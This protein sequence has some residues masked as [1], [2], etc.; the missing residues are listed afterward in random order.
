MDEYRVLQDALNIMKYAQSLK[1]MNQELYDH[2]CGSILYIIRYAD[3]NNM[4]LPDKEVLL[5]LITKS[6]DYIES[7]KEKKFPVITN[8]N[9]QTELTESYFRKNRR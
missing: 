4:A 5:G 6:E 1:R 9:D 7:I 3:K 8:N 2:L